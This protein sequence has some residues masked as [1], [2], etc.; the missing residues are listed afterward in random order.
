MAT[1]RI[2]PLKD[3]PVEVGGSLVLVGPDGAEEEV[4]ESPVYLCRCG[5]SRAKP[6]CDGSHKR[7]G[8]EAEGWQRIS[9]RR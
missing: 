1:T 9:T 5:L 2:R 4:G 7:A 8:F 3:G 6:F